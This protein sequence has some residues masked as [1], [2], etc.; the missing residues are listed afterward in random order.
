MMV[1]PKGGSIRDQLHAQPPK[2]RHG[3]ILQ[4]W[5]RQ[6]VASL[7]LFAFASDEHNEAL[8]SCNDIASLKGLERSWPVGVQLRR[9]C[10]SG[11]AA[12]AS[13]VQSPERTSQANE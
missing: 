11:A 4:I 3:R 13:P 10:G 1:W 7:M 12:F 8:G 6:E 9:H 2:W 5:S